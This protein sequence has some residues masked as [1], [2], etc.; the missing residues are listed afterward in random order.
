MSDIFR[1]NTTFISPIALLFISCSVVSFKSA[2]L[3][4]FV[5]QIFFVLMYPYRK[6]SSGVKS[7]ERS[8]QEMGP[9]R[10]IHLP[11]NFSLNRVQTWSEK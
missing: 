4:I 11:F 3:S 10:P 5:L 8:A 7:R 1:S 9:P 6:K 2:I